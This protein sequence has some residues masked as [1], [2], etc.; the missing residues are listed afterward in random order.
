MNQEEFLDMV[1]QSENLING[2]IISTDL[3]SILI[4]FCDLINI[5]NKEIGNLKEKINKIEKSEDDLNVMRKDFET[6][7]ILVAQLQNQLA[8]LANQTQAELIKSRQ[9][10]ELVKININEQYENLSQK[11]VELDNSID[12]QISSFVLKNSQNEEKI[13][14]KVEELAKQNEK[15][16]FDLH[17]LKIQ[18]TTLIHEQNQ[19]KNEA[20]TNVEE[21]KPPKKQTEEKDEVIEQSLVDVIRNQISSIEEKIEENQNKINEVQFNS[22]KFSNEIKT[23]EKKI[24]KIIDNETSI[25]NDRINSLETQFQSVPEIQDL[26]LSGK[27]IG[28][29]PILQA[30]MRDSRRLDSFDQQVSSVRIECENIA[31]EMV[32]LS[33]KVQQFNHQLFDFGRE[34]KN[35]SNKIVVDIQSIKKFCKFLGK[36]VNNIVSDISRITEGHHH[37]ASTIETTTDEISH[38]MV[39]ASGRRIQTLS[40]IEET[41]LEASELSTELSQKKVNLNMENQIQLLEAENLEPVSD[42]KLKTIDVSRYQKVNEPYKHSKL[43]ALYE[44]IEIGKNN[45]FDIKS[46]EEIRAKLNDIRDIFVSTNNSMNS[47][48][49]DL[50]KEIKKKM[51][52]SNVDRIITK[53]QNMLKTIQGEIN[54]IKLFSSSQKDNNSRNTRSFDEKDLLFNSFCESNIISSSSASIPLRSTQSCAIPRPNTATQMSIMNKKIKKKSSEAQRKSKNKDVNNSIPIIQKVSSGKLASSVVSNPKNYK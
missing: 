27:E 9:E 52:S 34:V 24:Q 28:L 2:S 15:L 47:K 39:L 40:L 17:E 3:N 36:A 45:E 30:I 23:S 32:A 21:P 5:Q 6:K 31:S 33:E 19:I 48:F 53:I 25:I 54:Q 18:L 7:S 35:N 8:I 12:N 29:T 46:V 38:L 16:D 11:M 13:K 43:L 42:E 37:L 51:D 10:T 1:K 14:N 22:L 50:S 49:D 41:N 44:D 20:Q 26:I 4:G